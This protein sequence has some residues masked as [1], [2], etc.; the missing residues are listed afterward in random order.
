MLAGN[1]SVLNTESN[2]MVKCHLI[3]LLVAVMMLSTPSS[4][5]PEPESMCPEL[6]SSISSPPSLTRS[7]PE[8]TDNSSPRTNFSERKMCNTSPEVIPIGKEFGRPRLDS[9]RNSPD[10]VAQVSKGSVCSTQLRR[11]WIGLGP[12]VWKSQFD[13]W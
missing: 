12:L 13:I 10:Q 8:P 5:K 2:L 4:P 9:T 3:K 11:N 1:C 7:E 6:S